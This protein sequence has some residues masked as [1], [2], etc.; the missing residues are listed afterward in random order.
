M[1]K[2]F[3]LICL[4]VFAGI[5]NLNAQQGGPAILFSR[6]VHDFGTIM[7][8]DGPVTCTFEFKN[9]GNQPLVLNNVAA[10]CG[11]TS[12]GWTREPIAPGEK[13]EVKAT[14]NPVGRVAPFDKTITVQ[15]NGT[16]GRIVLH[17]KGVVTRKPVD[18]KVSYP[19]SIGNLRLKKTEASIGV[20]ASNNTKVVTLE[21]ANA[22]DIPVSF[23][24]DKVP[25]YIKINAEPATLQPKQQGLIRIT[26]NAA[27]NKNFG[28]S[29][30]PIEIKVGDQ[31]GI[32]DITALVQEHI[33]KPSAD[34]ID[35]VPRVSIKSRTFDFGTAVKGKAVTAS[36]EITNEGK[37]ELV[38]HN[39]SSDNALKSSM[40]NETKIKAGKTVTIKLTYMPTEQGA[41]NCKA[42]LT[43]NDPGNTLIELNI[44][45]AVN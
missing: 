22:E 44:K 7:E 28:Y 41:N 37:N 5:I 10:S 3:S 38:L 11:C 27:Q 12:P 34:Q 2:I 40:K 8:S 39:I 23:S 43:T 42:Y 21:I 45:G 25:E 9:T 29:K 20:I 26:Y 19:L 31:K 4:L 1:K 18:L 24:F 13:G 36:Y 32:I 35:L 14:Y 16:P 6:T 15:S 17:I 33:E 30:N